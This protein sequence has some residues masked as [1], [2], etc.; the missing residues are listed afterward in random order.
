M[1]IISVGVGK[2]IQYDTYEYSTEHGDRRGQAIV[3][4]TTGMSY[5]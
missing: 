3:S 5:F 4:T 2:T 1:N